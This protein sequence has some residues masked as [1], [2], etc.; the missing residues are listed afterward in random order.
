M[1][2]IRPEEMSFVE[3]GIDGISQCTLWD[4]NTGGGASVVRLSA[5]AY[6]PSHS[7]PGWEQAR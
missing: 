1:F 5:N 6:F 3:S 4:N 2:V 7:H